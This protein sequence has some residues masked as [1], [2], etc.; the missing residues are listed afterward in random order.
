MI[1]ASE[2]LIVAA[3]A[4]LVLFSQRRGRPVQKSPDVWEVS[5]SVRIPRYLLTVIGAVL[6]GLVTAGAVLWFDLPGFIGTLATGLVAG[7]VAALLANR[8]R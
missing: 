1:G 6:A 4:L 2:I 8:R 3:I 7:L 5:A